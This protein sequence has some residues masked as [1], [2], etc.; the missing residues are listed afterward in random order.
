[1]SLRG[2]TSRHVAGTL[3]GVTA[4]A[5]A[6]RPD[7][8]SVK[9]ELLALAPNQV[10]SWDITCSLGRTQVDLLLLGQVVAGGKS[11][12]TRYVL[13]M[14]S[15]ASAPGRTRSRPRELRRFWL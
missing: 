14:C 13:A 3:Q 4:N 7:P 15:R 5:V 11:D 2:R 12:R 1:M 8:A 9:P 10:W 6:R